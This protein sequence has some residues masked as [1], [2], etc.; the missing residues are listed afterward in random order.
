MYYYRTYVSNEERT[1]AHSAGKTNKSQARI[2]CAELIAEGMLFDGASMI[3]GTYASE[4]FDDDSQW[5]LDKIQTSTGKAQTVTANT[6]KTYRHINF[7]FLIPFFTKK[8]IKRHQTVSHKEIQDENDWGRA[9]KQKVSFAKPRQEIRVPLCHW[10]SSRRVPNNSLNL[11]FGNIVW[12]QISVEKMSQEMESKFPP[13]AFF[14][15]YY[16]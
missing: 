10:V 15:A 3:F 14:L 4:F 11:Y 9:F 5:M 16:P 12:Q 6:L 8:K 7:A 2:Y 13:L 1:V